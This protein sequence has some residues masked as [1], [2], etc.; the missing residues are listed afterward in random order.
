[1]QLC[2]RVT[3]WVNRNFVS[4]RKERSRV[5]LLIK[6][7]LWCTTKVHAKVVFTLVRI[8]ERSCQF[9]IQGGVG[10]FGKRGQMQL[11][12]R[13]E[14][15]FH[16]GVFIFQ[17]KWFEPDHERGNYFAGVTRKNRHRY[18][19]IDRSAACLGIFLDV[20]DLLRLRQFV[21][22]ELH[23]RFGVQFSNIVGIQRLDDRTVT[24]EEAIKSRVKRLR[25]LLGRR[26]LA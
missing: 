13:P 19:F 12:V 5:E 16:P 17:L 14:S 3:Q 23:F 9:V 2:Q 1:M 21:Q 18:Q 24:V 6:Y 11:A 8:G 22:G 4:W 26:L 10:G 7:E 25:R 20:T 15:A